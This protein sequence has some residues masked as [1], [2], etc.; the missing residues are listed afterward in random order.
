MRRR[1]AGIFAVVV[2]A[3]IL[4]DVYVFSSLY[5]EFQGTG[6]EF[7]LIYW[8]PT[9]AFLLFLGFVLKKRFWLSQ[10]PVHQ[11]KLYQLMGLIILIFFP[12]ILTGVFFL[13]DDL[14]ILTG[15]LFNIT[16][17]PV[18]IFWMGV[19]LG[20]L[21]FLLVLY[22]ILYGRFHFKIEK[23]NLKFS[24]LPE[25]WSGLNI[26]HISDLHIGSWTR[27]K[28]QL[29]RAVR[30]INQEDPDL[31]LFTGDLINNLAE[32]LDPFKSI[33]KKLK[34]KNG[35]YSILGNHDYGD[36]F[37]WNSQREK[38]D[39]LRKTIHDHQEIGFNLLLN[40]SAILEK[41]GSSIGILGVENWG[42]PPFH[43]NGDLQ[44]TI[45]SL[46]EKTDFNI[47]LSHDPSHWKEEIVNHPEIDLT[48]SGH[49]HGMQFG[50]YTGKFK[51]SPAQWKYPE[52]G[53][54]YVQ[55]NHTLYVSTG[56]GFIGFPG[57]VGI[58][59][60]ITKITLLRE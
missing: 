26:I 13:L 24:S 59:P 23:L 8:L 43:Q 30:L 56:L 9:A 27:H 3:L 38:Q 50:V 18:F 41:D 15:R 21:V 32:E 51:W 52:W 6:D 44:R 53:G 36:Y 60:R 35:K 45:N 25:E 11:T 7:I 14:I 22:G 55:N 34:A 28:K 31:I 10:N 47:L 16:Q 29:E 20:I 33:L 58:R 39:N 48:L 17:A 49:T 5:D 40:D 57:R 46:K 42:L 2:T 1:F 4:V 54:L 19:G 37:H 12:K